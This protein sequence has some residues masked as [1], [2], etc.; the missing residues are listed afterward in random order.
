MTTTLK[1]TNKALLT[2]HKE[3]EICGLADKEFR[4]T[5]L[6][7]KCTEIQEHNGD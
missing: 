6:L 7:K 2:D 1:E 3:M 4:I 5:L